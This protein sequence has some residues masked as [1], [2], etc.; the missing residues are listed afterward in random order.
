[1]VARKCVPGIL[2]QTVVCIHEQGIA[3]VVRGRR[4]A[5]PL[6]GDYTAV[7]RETGR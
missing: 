6:V 4:C 2:A 3:A 1:M 5:L 7:S